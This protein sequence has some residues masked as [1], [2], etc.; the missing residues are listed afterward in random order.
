[1]PLVRLKP[2]IDLERSTSFVSV[3]L[4]GDPSLYPLE[5]VVSLHKNALLQG[6]TGR[7][8]FEIKE[9]RKKK[10]YFVLNIG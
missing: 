10:A 3:R 8:Y 7:S 4:F 5:L 1:M 2:V 9:Q 6:T